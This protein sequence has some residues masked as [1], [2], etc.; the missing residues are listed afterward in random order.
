MDIGDPVFAM[1]GVVFGVLA[2]A[3]QN[4]AVFSSTYSPVTTT[5]C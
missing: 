5:T 4:V 2:S 3:P 1:G